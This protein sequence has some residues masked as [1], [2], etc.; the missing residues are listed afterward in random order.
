MEQQGEK[1]LTTAQGSETKATLEQGVRMEG[2]GEA[3]LLNEKNEDGET[4]DGVTE[5]TDT[6]VIL[7]SL[8]AESN[9]PE[10]CGGSA[11]GDGS[12]SVK[13][14]NPDT[15]VTSEPLASD[16]GVSEHHQTCTEERDSSSAR[17][18]TDADERSEKIS[19]KSLVGQ[20]TSRRT[21]AKK[22]KTL[23]QLSA[24]MMDKK[25]PIQMQL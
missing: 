4:K 17:K 12:C 18:K 20:V 24:V 15:E 8:L 16:S 2:D 23:E 22:G 14:K 9:F 5:K 11:D 6:D 10:L 1:Q 7:E 21:S 13:K 19:N 25:R 3:V